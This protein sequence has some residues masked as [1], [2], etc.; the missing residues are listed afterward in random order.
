MSSIYY[1]IEFNT[2]IL[3]T[4]YNIFS[5]RLVYNNM[6]Y[7]E[8]SMTLMAYYTL[9][10]YLKRRQDGFYLT[11]ASDITTEDEALLYLD[12]IGWLI[13]M[14]RN[15]SND[16]SLVIIQQKHFMSCQAA[17]CYCQRGDVSETFFV[18]LSKAELSE[19]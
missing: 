11:K 6:I 2:A 14:S 7:L 18:Y 4:I 3:M 12:Y 16:I 8:I 17:N 13:K 10:V 9:A 5:F 1:C 15:L 19:I